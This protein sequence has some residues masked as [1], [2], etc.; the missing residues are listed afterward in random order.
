MAH[1]LQIWQLL[2]SCL[3]LAGSQR[4]LMLQLPIKARAAQLHT[5]VE[6]EPDE[7]AGCCAALVSPAKAS[8]ASRAKAVNFILAEVLEL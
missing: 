3:V 6:P 8:S 5:L 1:A 2:D 7:R 4:L